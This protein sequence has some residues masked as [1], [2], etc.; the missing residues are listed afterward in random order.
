VTYLGAVGASLLGGLIATVLVVS[1]GSDDVG[2]SISPVPG[3]SFGNE[4]LLRP[5]GAVLVVLATFWLGALAASRV[6]RPP[7]DVTH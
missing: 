5:L 1:T 6:E 4:H 3:T 2:A 7:V